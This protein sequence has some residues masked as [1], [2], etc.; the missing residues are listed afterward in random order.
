MSILLNVCYL[1]VL[2]LLSPAILWVSWRTG[3]YREGFREKFLG[4]LPVRDNDRPCIWFHAV[5][6][7]EVNLLATTLKRI[8]ADAPDVDCLITTTTKTGYQLALKKYAN[9]QVAYCPLD[10][11]WAVRRAMKRVQPNLLVLVELEIWPN[12]INAASRSS[13]PIALINGRI[14]ERSYRGYQRIRFFIRRLLKQFSCLGVQTE[15]YAERFANLGATPDQILVTGSVKFDGA[16]T[17][18]KNAQTEKLLELAGLHEQNLVLLAGSTMAGEEQLAINA[19]RE[20]ADDFPELRLVIVPRHPERF[21]DVAR[22]L[23]QS[24]L[25][26]CRRTRLEAQSRPDVQ[27]I[28]VD[29]IGELGGWWGVADLAFVGGSISPERGGQNM[30]EPAA[31]GAA[32]CFGPH[33]YNFRDVVQRLL[34]EEAAQVV[35]DEEELCSFLRRCLDCR[36]DA[37]EMGRRAQDLVVAN[38]GATVRTVKMLLELLPPSFPSAETDAVDDGDS[39]ESAVKFFDPRLG[40]ERRSA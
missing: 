31:Y 6:V 30:I 5:S 33:T 22:L 9:H 3:K 37:S 28:L 8:E 29:T 2:T 26:W 1:L 11:S 34:K 39:L 20:L 25:Q 38:Q 14:S 13:V 7:G 35:N 21:D 24:A 27:V 23:D 32:V 4:L 18:R 17:D 40:Y 19:F 16:E 12:L 15:E 36:S 10:F